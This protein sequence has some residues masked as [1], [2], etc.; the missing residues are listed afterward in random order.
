MTKYNDYCMVIIRYTSINTNYHTP[1]LQN[2]GDKR[3]TIVPNYPNVG[4]WIVIKYDI[5][6]TKERYYEKELK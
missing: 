6:I 5:A 1:I 4:K 3:M 2:K